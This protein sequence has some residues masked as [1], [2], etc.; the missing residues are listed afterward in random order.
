MSLTATWTGVYWH[1]HNRK[2]M[3]AL[4]IGGRFATI[5]YFADPEEAAVVYD[6]AVIAYRPAGS[7]TNLIAWPR[8]EERAS[9]HEVEEE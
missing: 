2:W 9:S 4:R 5:G 7:Y 6:A 8:T 1:A 3:V